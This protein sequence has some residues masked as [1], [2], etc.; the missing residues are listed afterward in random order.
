M[1]VGQAALLNAVYKLNDK[2]CSYTI[3]Q[4]ENTMARN[5]EPGPTKL[6]I[7]KSAGTFAKLMRKTYEKNYEKETCASLYK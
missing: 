4:K 2:A 1:C 5:Q 6:Q 3:H 7:I